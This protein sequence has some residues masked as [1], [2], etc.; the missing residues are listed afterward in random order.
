SGDLRLTFQSPLRLKTNGSYATTIDPVALV[1]AMSWRLH[2]LAT[3]HGGGPWETDRRRLTTLAQQIRVAE[4]HMQWV[5]W[6]RTSTS[7]SQRQKMNLGGL[8]GSVVLQNVPPA[9]R[10]VLL[11]G[12]LVHV[13]KACVFGHGQYTVEDVR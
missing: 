10:S 6:S 11:A 13:G 9:I 5:E 1:R 3:F 2:A 7:G 8:V 4:E 12:S